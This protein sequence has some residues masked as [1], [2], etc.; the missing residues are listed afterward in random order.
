MHCLQLS[1]LP[2][3]STIQANAWQD[4]DRESRSRTE[5]PS[6]H[7][8]RISAHPA[9]LR[10]SYVWQSALWQG[11]TSGSPSF[12]DPTP[13]GNDIGWPWSI[14]EIQVHNQKDTYLED[15]KFRIQTSRLWLLAARWDGLW[16]VTSPTAKYKSF[17]I[18]LHITAVSDWS[19]FAVDVPS[20]FHWTQDR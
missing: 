10:S 18:L 19:I 12:Y 20:A 4:R 1:Y 13:N 8:Q 9:C 11:I 14:N 17:C 15:L 16:W 7:R 6:N 5:R 2:I 3:L